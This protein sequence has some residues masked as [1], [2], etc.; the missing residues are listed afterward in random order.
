M[1][2]IAGFYWKAEFN[3][4]YIIKQFDESDKEILFKEVLCKGE[5]DLKSFKL[6]NIKDEEI[7]DVDFVNQS[8]KLKGKKLQYIKGDNPQLIYRRRIVRGVKGVN[9]NLMTTP[10][11]IKH[12]VG[13]RT[14]KEIKIAEVYLEQNTDEFISKII[15]E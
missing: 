3:D 14:N 2:D 7:V 11:M 9:G 5:E 4:N 1:G 15:K 12:H 8:I 6:F 10:S 13:I